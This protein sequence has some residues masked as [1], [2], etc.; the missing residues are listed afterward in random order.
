MA[1]DAGGPTVPIYGKPGLSIRR[2][3]VHGV[4]K[5]IQ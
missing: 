1:S 2:D 5:G 3:K 4:M